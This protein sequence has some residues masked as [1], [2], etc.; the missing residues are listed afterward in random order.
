MILPIIAYG[1]PVL[2][3]KAVEIDKDYPKLDEL[4]ANMYETMYGASGVGLA[5]P[6]VG[7]AIRMFLVDASPFAEDDDFSEEEKAQLKDFKKTFINPIILEEEG[8]EWA[9]NE[10]CLSI[11][12]VREDVFRQPK[13]KIQYQDE[14]FNTYVEEYDG[15]IAR[16]IQHEYDHIE[17]VLF[18]DKLSSFKKRLLKG[19]LQN[20]SKGK[21]R[22]DYRMRFPAMS[23]KR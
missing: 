14:D 2:K 4:I 21:I 16:V 9:F 10:G 13:I 19:K 8:D 5:A 3:K 18:T 22:V 11:P 6:Q 1:D 7:L 12:D 20:I 15:L 23:K 17:G